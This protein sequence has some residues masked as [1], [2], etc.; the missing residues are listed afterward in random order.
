MNAHLFNLLRLTPVIRL[1][2]ARESE[3][4]D[5]QCGIF[6]SSWQHTA[7]TRGHDT[8]IH[9]QIRLQCST[10]GQQANPFPAK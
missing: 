2:D 8:G 10:E 9:M 5:R 4:T 1:S 6:R 7:Y 3:N